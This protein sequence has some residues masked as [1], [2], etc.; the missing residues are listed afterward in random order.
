MARK[1]KKQWTREPVTIAGLETELKD[2]QAQH[3]QTIGVTDSQREVIAES[4]KLIGVLKQ[5]E[6]YLSKR[7]E[8]LSHENSKRATQSMVLRTALTAS[9]CLFEQNEKDMAKVMVD[10]YRVASRYADVLRAKDMI[11]EARKKTEEP[12]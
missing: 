7:V 10:Y 4:E 3:K 8:D 1:R 9:S 6:E 11:D 12:G 5:R 2:L